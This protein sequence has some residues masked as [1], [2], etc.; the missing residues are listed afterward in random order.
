M[1]LRAGRDKETEMM[2]GKKMRI[3]EAKERRENRMAGLGGRP[4][5][6]AG[7]DRRERLSAVSGTASARQAFRSR[8]LADGSSPSRRPLSFR[9]ETA[10]S[11]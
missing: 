3:L 9:L 11:R 4:R 6:L 5:E 8:P 1:A 2:E 7:A 10:T